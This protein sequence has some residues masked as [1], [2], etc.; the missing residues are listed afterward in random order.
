MARDSN[1][2]LGI[3]WTFGNLNGLINN[4]GETL[5]HEVGLRC[6]CNNE[7]THAGQI[8]RT[9][10]LRKRKIVNC[11]QCNGS[12][13]MYRDPRRVVAL[14]TAISE[15]YVRHEQG[16]AEPGDCVMSVKTDVTI[17]GGDR[18]TF[19]WGQPLNEGQVIVRGAGTSSENTARKTNLNE[20]E[21]RLW[22]N[23]KNNIWCEDEN[24]R[25]YR[26]GSDFLLDGSK[27][28]R[29]IGGQPTKHKRYTIK[30]TAY[31]EWIAFVPPN[32][33]R[34][35]DRDLGTRVLLRKSHAAFVNDNPTASVLDRLP[36]CDRIR[37]CG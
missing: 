24:S 12:G 26:E 33:R 18:V 5:I 7:D 36:F 31:F 30:Y 6:P 25:R 37:G 34:D 23:A 8:E 32:I 29:W 11:N 14:I 17:S 2:G 1:L 20:D 27:V 15:D 35:R 4:R 3:D 9:H 19:T 28:I 21:D 10:V 16:W 13:Y 22:Y